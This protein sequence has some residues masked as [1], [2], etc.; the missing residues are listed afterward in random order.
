MPVKEV[1]GEW[2]WVNAEGNPIVHPG[3]NAAP[4]WNAG[5]DP[6]DPIGLPDDLPM[7]NPPPVP[8]KQKPKQQEELLKDDGTTMVIHGIRVKKDDPRII[9]DV[10]TNE[11]DFKDNCVKVFVDIDK[12]KVGYTRNPRKCPIG[13]HAKLG[14]IY[15][16]NPEV[17]IN[18][19]MIESFVNGQFFSPDLFNNNYKDFRKFENDCD[20]DGYNGGWKSRT[21]LSTEGLKYTFGVELEFSRLYIPEYLSHKYNMKCMRDG[22]LNAK[23]GGPEI[24]TGVLTGDAGMNHLQDMCIELAKRGTIDEYCGIHVHVGGFSPTKEFITLA[25]ILGNKLE[26]EIISIMPPTRKGNEYCRSIRTKFTKTAFSKEYRERELE[27]DDYFMS[28]YE[29]LSHYQIQKGKEVNRKAQHPMGAKCQYDHSTPRYCWLNLI[30]SAFNIRGNESWTIEFRN[31][32]GSSNF[33]KIY[34]WIKLCMAFVHFVENYKERILTE[35]LT[36][37]DIIMAAYPKTGHVL[38]G[39]IEERKAKFNAGATAGLKEERKEYKEGCGEK[40][41]IKELICVS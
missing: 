33:V 6:I 16:A 29:W 25:Y 15:G 21:Y 41:S 8:K 11:F 9:T 39:Y 31:H 1:N 4:G 3:N 30:P 14:G 17:F 24:V 5:N 38:C 36:L 20:L 2:V 23:Q 35:N 32:P 27:L 12:N 7:W 19:G 18:A 22:S 34:N 26:N 28:I 13:Q 40:K 10:V 37:T